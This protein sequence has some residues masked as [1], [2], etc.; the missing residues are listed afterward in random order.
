MLLHIRR[1]N[2]RPSPRPT[3]PVLLSPRFQHLVAL[4]SN[5]IFFFYFP[6]AFI[7][8]LI[9][10][11]GTPRCSIIGECRRS[12]LL[13]STFWSFPGSRNLPIQLTRGS[14]SLA[15]RLCSAAAHTP[16]LPCYLVAFLFWIFLLSGVISTPHRAPHLSKQSTGFF[17]L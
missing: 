8:A 16:C 12:K 7:V 17:G 14:V 10:V 5:F 15:C 9:L 4:S 2:P 6:P 1:K 3:Y 11:E 13:H